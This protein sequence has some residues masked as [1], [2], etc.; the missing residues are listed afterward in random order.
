[1]TMNEPDVGEKAPGFSL[2]DTERKP[3]TLDE[4]LGK[5]LVVAFYPGAFTSVCT[6]EMCAFRD[7]IARLEEL[8]SGVAGISV[9]D[10]F[11]NAAFAERNAINFPLLSDYKRE[12]AEAFGVSLESFAGM[13]GYTAAKRSIF[14]VDKQGIVRYKWVTEDQGVEPDYEDI[15]GVLAE[16]G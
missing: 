8:D 12:A 13:S 7:S 4:F 6:K 10:P 14:I 1:M 3:R 5:N 11:T 9:N 15:Q 16:I 2:L